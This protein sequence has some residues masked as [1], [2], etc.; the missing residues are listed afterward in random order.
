MHIH[1]ISVFL[2]NRI[3]QLSEITRLLADAGVDIRA[4]SIGQNVNQRNQQNDFAED[5][6]KHG[7]FCVPD[8]DECLLAGQ[9]CAHDNR[10][11]HVYAHGPAAQVNEGGVSGEETGKQLRES[12]NAQPENH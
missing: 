9:L 1:Q 5:S 2:E 8:G 12:H 7:G 3:G 4:L 11:A 6:Q 10:C